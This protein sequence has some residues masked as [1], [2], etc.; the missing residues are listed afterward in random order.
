MKQQILLAVLAIG[1]PAQDRLSSTD[2]RVYKTGDGKEVKE[3]W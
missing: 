3:G 1:V 2:R